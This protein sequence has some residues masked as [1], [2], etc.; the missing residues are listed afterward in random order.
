[1]APKFYLLRTDK[2]IYDI[3]YMIYTVKYTKTYTYAFS[4]K[5][6]THSLKFSLRS[7]I[8]FALPFAIII[9]ANSIPKKNDNTKCN[10][11]LK[12]IT[13]SV[14]TIS[15][16]SN[17]SYALNELHILHLNDVI[18]QKHVTIANIDISIIENII[19][20]LFIFSLFLLVSHAHYSIYA[21]IK[22][23]KNQLFIIISK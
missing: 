7:N 20:R 14:A 1:M 6:F 10:E 23:S 8:V 9:T 15:A 12:D 17:D 18:T 4:F 22:C 13:Y 16:F 21:I 5:V 11:I 19:L 3:K 2:I